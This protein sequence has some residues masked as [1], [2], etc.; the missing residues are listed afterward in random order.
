MSDGKTWKRFRKIN[1]FEKA[2]HP[3]GFKGDR[4]ELGNYLGKKAV[5]QTQT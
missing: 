2:S 1:V 3:G 5:T 4:K